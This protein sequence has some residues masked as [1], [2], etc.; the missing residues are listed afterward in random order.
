MATGGAFNVARLIREL[1]LKPVA[2]DE[3][4]MRV[5]QTIQPTLQVGDLSH[6]T[7]PHVGASAMFGSIVIG[8]A[9]Q[10]G[11]IELQSLAPGGGFVEWVMV[12]TNATG[13]QM[14]VVTTP[15][16][17][18]IAVPSAGQLSRDPV[19]STVVRGSVAAT[20]DPSVV[21]V[22]DIDQFRFGH[23]PLFIPRGSIFQVE[24]TVDQQLSFVN[25]GWREVPAPEN[26]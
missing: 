19:L 17:V 25:F 2:G 8:L 16:G 5:L 26:L 21:I 22:A 14:R 11:I 23:T 7:P 18:A 24:H 13:A 3:T 4:L 9:A 20:G 15:S 6:T 10:R 12:D 1:G